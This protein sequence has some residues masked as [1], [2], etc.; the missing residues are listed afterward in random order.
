MNPE[1]LTK[2]YDEF[3]NLKAINTLYHGHYSH[4]GHVMLVSPW[5]KVDANVTC[6]VLLQVRGVIFEQIS[7][8]Q[9]LHTVVNQMRK[10]IGVLMRKIQLI[11][12]HLIRSCLGESSL[13]ESCLG[14]SCLGESFWEKAVGRKLLGESC[15]GES[16]LKK[17]V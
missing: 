15:L 6:E 3:I 17:A 7:Q 13:G 12:L 4:L 5:V 9:S 11:R 14:E 10:I 2:G 16:C 8:C 1:L